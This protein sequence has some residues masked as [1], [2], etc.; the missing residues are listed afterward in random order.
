MSPAHD[1][2]ATWT[3]I[4]TA[5][6]YSQRS[7]DTSVLATPRAACK[8]QRCPCVLRA[9]P[10]LERNPMSSLPRTLLPWL[11]CAALAL[12]AC[13]GPTREAPQTARS[14][15]TPGAAVAAEEY[16][17]S[18]EPS[19]PADKAAAPPTA[20]PRSE[21]A[22]ASADRAYQ[23]VPEPERPG[24]GTEWGETRESRVSSAPFE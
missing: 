4:A 10:P 17:A 16:S 19:A 2:A 14:A 18:A 23:P 12:A 5:S 1:R 6:R 7:E 13:G 21:S 20:A 8:P 24:L 22:G 15:P 3:P 11:G 9:T